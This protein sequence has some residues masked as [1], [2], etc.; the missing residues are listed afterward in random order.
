MGQL[1]KKA[2][3]ILSEK[4]KLVL[5]LQHLEKKSSWEAGEVLDLAH[6][7]LLEIQYRANH[8]FKLFT[9]YFTLFPEL[10]CEEVSGNKEVKK[11]LELVI[12]KRLPVHEAYNQLNEAFGFTG[13]NQ[14]DREIEEQLTT[15]GKSDNAYELALYDLVKEFDRWNNFRVLP[16]S[17][18]EPSA[19]KRRNKN[20]LKKHIKVTTSVPDISIEKI[21]KLFGHKKGYK[22]I[23]LPIITETRNV[24]V[25]KLKGNDKTISELTTLNLYMFDSASRANEYIQL[26]FEYTQQGTKKCKVGLE[27]WP[28]YR[29]IIKAAINYEPIQKI[30]PARRYLQLALKKLTYY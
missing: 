25:F 29:E 15:W 8:F 16:P 2:Y 26:I 18:R 24:V 22:A 28:K 10:I 23:Y 14:R 20:I 11:Y 27:F 12:E 19:F 5:N 21:E 6:Y 13:K 7:K 1:N 30:V 3:S 17:L 4:E 9:S